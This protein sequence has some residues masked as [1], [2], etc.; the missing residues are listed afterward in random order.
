MRFL[1]MTGLLMFLSMLAV[2]CGSDD[3]NLDGGESNI[4]TEL[5]VYVR[6][7]SDNVLL[8]GVDVEFVQNN[9]VLCVDTTNDYGTALCGSVW[10][11]LV[12]G[13][14]T[15]NIEVKG[16][17]AF[18]KTG[19]IDAGHNTLEVSL[20]PEI[21]AETAMTLTSENVADFYGVLSID[22]EKDVA[23]V[24]V[25]EG[26]KYDEDAYDEYKNDSYGIQGLIQRVTY[27][28][29]LP[30][31]KYTFTVASFDGNK[32][33][34]ETKTISLITKDIYNRSTLK[35]DIVDFLAIG[36]GISVTLQSKPENGFYLSCYELDK[37]PSNEIQIIKDA[38]SRGGKIRTAQIGYVDGLKKGTKYRVY[39]IPVSSRLI[40]DTG[41]YYDAPGKL[42]YMDLSTK[43]DSN[44][45]QATVINTSYTKS[46][47]SYYIKSS[48][49]QNNTPSGCMSYRGV[50]I[51]EYDQ[52]EGEP[53]IAWA[54]LCH[55]QTL[56]TFTSQ[57]TSTY[58]W[59]DLNLTSWYGIVTLGYFDS[60]G[61]NYSSIIS[62]YK[63]KYGSY[64]V[65]TATATK[66]VISTDN[67]G[68]KYGAITDDMLKRV[69]VLK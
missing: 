60:R 25:S 13:M 67:S 3:E 7:A 19:K 10:D 52:F 32:K 68:I 69:R 27:T 57:N 41:Y 38:L 58:T 28:N 17:K 42:T 20:T 47:F 26:S 33:Q 6:D 4:T 63:F 36:N 64:G 43:G 31:T 29:L 61:Q 53:D 40:S 35:L 45:A 62:R 34:L 48:G 9:K 12:P 30:N 1:K 37:V 24:R 23:F 15:I 8:K 2:G 46:S 44:V 5:Y 56:E 39:I 59:S 65:T 49:F 55:G 22:V 51:E 21:I 54:T 50:T 16:Y 66:S 14:V 18:T 11:G